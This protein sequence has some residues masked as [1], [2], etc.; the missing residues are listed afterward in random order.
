MPPKRHAYRPGQN[1]KNGTG[2]RDIYSP[3]TGQSQLNQENQLLYK[4]KI[5]NNPVKNANV[6]HTRGKKGNNVFNQLKKRP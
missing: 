6:A 5:I 4:V 2:K 3:N 1:N